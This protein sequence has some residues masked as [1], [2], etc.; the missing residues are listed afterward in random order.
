MPE[1]QDPWL[2]EHAQREFIGEG[3]ARL[4]VDLDDIVFHSDLDE[5]PRAE[6]VRLCNPRGFVVFE[7]TLH[8]FA[9]DWLHP[10]PCPPFPAWR[11]TVAGRVRHIDKFATMRDARLRAPVVLPDAGWHFSWMGGADLNASKMKSFAHPEIR[12]QWENRTLECWR[13][14]IHVDGTKLLPID[15]DDTFPQWI[16]TS[17]PQSWFRPR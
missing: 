10:D 8:P 12:P 2:R 15:I 13:D 4:A 14:G 16:H 11:G 6:H 9:V 3:L 5:I 7:Q 1:G 17:A